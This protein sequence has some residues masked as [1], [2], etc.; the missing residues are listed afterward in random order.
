MPQQ[1]AYGACFL[2]PD[3]PRFCFSFFLFS[4]YAVIYEAPRRGHC[5][6][7]LTGDEKNAKRG[8]RVRLQPVG[9]SAESGEFRVTILIS[10]STSIEGSNSQRFPSISC[11]LQFLFGRSVTMLLYTS[12]APMRGS[13]NPEAR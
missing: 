1:L 7:C 10:G 3:L 11:Q 5:V 8:K 9:K 13:A 2:G 6:Y 4:C 12:Y